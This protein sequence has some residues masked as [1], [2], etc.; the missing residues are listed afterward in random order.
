MPE[1]T[2]EV[3]RSADALRSSV[4][5]DSSSNPSGTVSLQTVAMPSSANPNGDIF[6]G[7]IMSQMDIA[8]GIH[9][10][11]AAGGRVA[12]VAVDAMAFEL[13]VF[14]GDVV[15]CYCETER[16]G[17]TSI[18]VRVEVWVRRRLTKTVERVTAG[19]FTF[20]AI[21]DNGRPRPVTTPN[22]D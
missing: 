6:G 5:P 10:L 21:D 9:A 2:N 15:T 3:T 11:D 19:T 7:W 14:V 22:G 8:G 12:T 18:A 17:T 13:P 16:I 4:K 20:V 1:A